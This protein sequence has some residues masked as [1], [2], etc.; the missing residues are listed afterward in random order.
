M[1]VSKLFENILF[2]HTMQAYEKFSL[3]QN[4]LWYE[5][6]Q[7]PWFFWLQCVCADNE[8]V[9]SWI[10]KRNIERE[11]ANIESAFNK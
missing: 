11:A 2:E 6:N 10:E 5:K 1:L 8:N 3:F 4:S 7:L 9:S